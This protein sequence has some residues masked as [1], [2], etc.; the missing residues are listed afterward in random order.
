MMDHLESESQKQFYNH[1]KK[2]VLQTGTGI[3]EYIDDLANSGLGMAPE[4]IAMMREVGNLLQHHLDLKAKV[5]KG[6]DGLVAEP[7]PLWADG[8]GERWSLVKQFLVNIGFKQEDIQEIDDVTTSILNEGFEPPLKKKFTVRRS[9]V[10]GYVQS[11][12]T[13]NFISL[14]SKAADSGYRFILVLTGITNNLREQTQMRLDERLT[15]NPEQWIKLTTLEKDFVATEDNAAAFFNAAKPGNITV[16][17]VMKKNASRLRSLIAWLET[18][19]STTRSNLPFLII[20]DEADQATPNSSKKKQTEINKLV[21]KIA[22][23]EFMPRNV[24]VAYTATPFA[25][26]LMDGS[27][28]KNLY[29]RDLV[30]PIKA[31][32][33]YFGAAELFGRNAIDEDDNEVLPEVN[34]LRE[35]EEDE[36]RKIRDNKW[37]YDAEF[38]NHN[39]SLI[40]ALLWFIL[41][42]AVREYREGKRDFSTMMIHTSSKQQDHKNMR[43]SLE[44][45][46]NDLADLKTYK[47]KIEP[48]LQAMWEE[49]L[50]DPNVIFSGPAPEWDEIVNSCQ[51]IAQAIEVKV[52]NHVSKD[53]IHYSDKEAFPRVPKIVIGG[54]T[55]SRG[56]TLEGLITSYFLRASGQCDSVLQLGRWFGYRK[57]YEDLQRIFMPNYRP[58]EFM[59]W[60]KSLAL[61]EAD[62]RQQIQHMHNDN[63]TPGQ[64]PIK[65]RNHPYLA[66]TASAKA[67]HATQAQISFANQRE[68]VT[69]HPNSKE[70]L[71]HNLSNA[72]KFV[73]KI[74]KDYEFDKNNT[75]RNYPVFYDI[76]SSVIIE[77]LEG[78]NFVNDAK[79][80]SSKAWT[81]YIKKANSFNE[82][83]F[84]NVFIGSPIK[85][86]MSGTVPLAPGLDISKI[87]RAGKS[88][89]DHLRTVTLSMP[90]DTLSDLKKGSLSQKDL[91]VLKSRNLDKETIFDIRN[92]GLG[93]QGKS[94]PGLIGLYVI[95][96]DSVP[97]NWDPAKPLQP[98]QVTKPLNA[99]A[100]VLAITMFFPGTSEMKL[101]VDYIAIDPSK[102]A[103]FDD[104]EEDLDQLISEAEEA[105]KNE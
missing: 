92:R 73:T 53:R 35:V 1:L 94:V 8:E 54:N 49:E 71:V 11:G 90:F 20:D 96:K 4:N 22:D 15:L 47:S 55:L 79:N 58:L 10:L 39:D 61:L 38:S 67:R 56:L 2:V 52:D 89:P 85:G 102:I 68:D 86:K 66:I 7:K 32:S 65:I 60:F 25:N 42:T 105:D 70:S 18:L 101:A 19:D 69:L 13:T 82:L 27:S 43:N 100:D 99:P 57:G 46:I 33:G 77:F 83:D 64:L 9:L 29:P 21:E 14:I 97:K 62:L 48:R 30:Y 104:E 103:V 3:K 76:P 51:A 37:S 78:H 63:V 41:A 26:L 44:Q 17:A 24:Y 72:Q 84:W 12:K 98:L 80:V 36:V 88:H 91:D 28:E 93:K 6:G 16:I 74:N 75:F 5:V 40:K 87:S 23:P 45:Y 95:D 50:A 81:D 31:G 59:E 34:I